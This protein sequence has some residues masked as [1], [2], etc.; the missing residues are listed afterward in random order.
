M[1]DKPRVPLYDRLPELY[2]I[3]DAKIPGQPLAAFLALVEDAFGAVHENIEALYH[4]LFIDTCDD[5]V[6]PY[7][8]DLLGTSHLKGDP[9][10]VRRDVAGTIG[11]RRRKGTLGVIEALTEALT[12]WGV[13]AAELFKDLAWAQ[14]LDHQ[15]PDAGGLPP[16]GLATVDRH[17]VARGGTAVIRDP[18]TLALLATPFDPFAHLPDFRIP[19]FGS[20]RINLPN[21]AVFLW[22]LAA[23]R[24]GPVRPVHRGTMTTGLGDELAR[25]V[26]RFDLHPLG[27]AVRLF[28]V[29]K[30]EN[31]HPPL[32]TAVDLKPGPIH[33]ARLDSMRPPY[34]RSRTEPASPGVGELWLEPGS[35]TWREWD[36]SRWKALEELVVEELVSGGYGKPEAYVAVATY[37][38]AGGPPQRASDLALELHLP[39]APFSPF[40]PTDWR[41]RGADLL[42]WEEGLRQPLRDKEIA[43]DPRIGRLAIGV[44]TAGQAEQVQ[45]HLRVVLTYG[46]VGPVGAHPV[47][48]VPAPPAT[49]T[50]GVGAPGGD[51]ED[52][53]G[54]L[55][56]AGSPVVVEIADDEVHDLDLAAVAGAV[57]ETGGPTLRL[58][59]SLTVRAADGKRPIVR[60]ARPLRVRAL[61]AARAGSIAVRLEGIYLARGAGWTA[62]NPLVARADVGS[63][64]LDG[65]TLDPGGA[66]G[67]CDASGRAPNHP[68]IRLRNGDRVVTAGNAA[69]G[70]APTVPEVHLRRT[71]TGPLR[72]DRGYR[73]FLTESILDAG[74]GPQDDPATAGYALSGAGEPAAEVWGPEVSVD[75]VTFFGRVRVERAAGRGGIWTQ[76]CEVLDNQKGCIKFS[77]FSGRGDR[78]PQTHAC[79]RGSGDDAAA[80]RFVSEA[81]GRPEYGQLAFTAD[82]R[83]RER[84]PQDDAM[85]AFGFLLEAHKWRNLEIRYREFMPLGIRPLPIPV[86]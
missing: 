65:C 78:L 2:R 55:H 73:L 23:Y 12:G 18:A 84:G 71:L 62:G 54:D 22:R 74:S 72:I 75:S 46:A 45:R 77:Y 48:R 30:L 51:L 67:T 1:T 83:I 60:L 47:D 20:L 5:W 69:A 8:A 41:F 59:Q 21:L 79:V 57:N 33:P 82:F 17:T 85:G 16:Y 81:F 26:L 64:V 29:G 63:L 56:T 49:R 10:T 76:P 50:V 43:I 36:G 40:E 19:H 58:A 13:H 34:H 86:T 39:E 9:R 80:L 7:L 66:F 42:G 24:V 6:I 32:V 14:E 11:W 38:P 15:R 27:E 25:R 53:L 37:D 44:R 52:A 68:G 35:D 28:N 4:D 61:D 3:E 31:G 70:I